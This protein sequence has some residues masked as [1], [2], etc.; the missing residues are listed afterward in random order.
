MIGPGDCPLGTNP[1]FFG[2]EAIIKERT[3][4]A[5]WAMSLADPSSEPDQIGMKGI[6]F[7]TRDKLSHEMEGLFRGFA[8]NG[9]TQSAAKAVHVCVHRKNVSSQREQKDASGCFHTNAVQR[10][11]FFDYLFA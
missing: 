8:A 10:G 4:I 5:G 2:V 1:G 3:D 11:E 7:S 6:A 9:Q